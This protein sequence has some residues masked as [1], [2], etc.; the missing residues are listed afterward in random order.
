MRKLIKNNLKVF[1]AIILTAIICISVTAYAAI[2]IQ[3]D[4]IGYKDGT[5]ESALNDLY[6]L[7]TTANDFE[8][9]I[10]ELNGTYIAIEVPSNVASTANEFLYYIN[11]ELKETSSNSTYVYSD[12]QFSTNYNIKV[13]AN[14][15]TTKTSSIIVKTLD[16]LYLYNDG[17][18][19]SILT[20]GWSVGAVD[21]GCT[22]KRGLAS[23]NPTNILLYT[24]GFGC[25]LSQMI[26]NSNIDISTYTGVYVKYFKTATRG[27]SVN[28]IR[29]INESS[30]IQSIGGYLEK[31]SISNYN[32]TISI[33][34]WNSNDYITEVYVKD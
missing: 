6:N 24:S 1:V 4:E 34:S 23:K 14:G 2:R 31:F 26:T 12:L 25:S 29:V 17:N 18:E 8:L 30:T 13:V 3:A 5:V 11:G 15:E 21:E 9:N 7:A 20:G 28:Q 33:G 22:P 16:K 10:A 32:G 19:Y 27:S